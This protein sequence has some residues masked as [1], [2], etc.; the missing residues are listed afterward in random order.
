MTSREQREQEEYRALRATIRER[1]TARSWV[2]VFGLSVWACLALSTLVLTSIPAATLLPLFV[3]AGTFEVVFALH[4]SVERIGRYLQVHY[5]E[6]GTDRNWEHVAMAFGPPL[7]GTGAD[8]LFTALFCLA[9]L[10][11]GLTAVFGG[12]TRVEMG[13]VGA[14]HILLI[15]RIATARWSAKRQRLA[16]LERFQGIKS[17]ASRVP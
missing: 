1:G 13:V 7:A 12:A 10:F 5:E 8:P 6:P 14:A 9:T 4:V 2:F 17:S 15:A 3:L 16:D 11:N